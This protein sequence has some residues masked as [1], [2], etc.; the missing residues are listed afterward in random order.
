L[1]A[2]TLSTINAL[3]D[4][5]GVQHVGQLPLQCWHVFAPAQ[6]LYQTE[7]AVRALL[8]PDASILMASINSTGGE[9]GSGSGRIC[10]AA[11][12]PASSFW[13]EQKLCFPWHLPVGPWWWQLLQQ[14]RATVE[15]CTSHFTKFSL[16]LGREL[17]C[18][19]GSIP[20]SQAAEALHH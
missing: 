15:H 10:N 17:V 16:K 6:N 8:Q 18:H 12:L 4:A 13:Q 14:P 2:A 7:A 1:H 19:T 3:A 5:A 11:A 9:P 20:Q